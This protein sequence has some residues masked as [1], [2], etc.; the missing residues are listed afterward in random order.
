MLK[1]KRINNDWI[2]TLTC[3][4][5]GWEESEV[6][7]DCGEDTPQFNDCWDLRYWEEDGADWHIC[8]RCLDEELTKEVGYD[9]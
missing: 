8:P 3:N 6:F 2:L 7:K 1:L 9:I 5:C 4:A